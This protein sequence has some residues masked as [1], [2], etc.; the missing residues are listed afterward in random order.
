MAELGMDGSA[1]RRARILAA[2]LAEAEAVGW[3]DL[4]LRHV[5]ERLELPLS[6]VQAEFRDADAIADALFQQALQAMLAAGAPPGFAARPPSARTAAVLL[7][8]FDALA[9]HRALAGEMIREKLWPS[10]PHHWVPMV[11]SL[12]RLIH[13]VRE[14]ALLDAGGL[15]RQ[16]EEVGLT[17]V[18]LR[19]LPDWLSA[20]GADRAWLRAGLA[21][22]LRWLDRLA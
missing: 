6:A 3:H 20:R 7:R 18:F 5:A 11:F 9:P 10:H 12:S 4:R 21:R 15:R 1:A 22:R 14:A 19:S 2:A 16:A 17:L 13:W 8:W